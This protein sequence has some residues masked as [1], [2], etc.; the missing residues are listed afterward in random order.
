[1]L[2]TSNTRSFSEPFDAS[3]ADVILMCGP[4]KTW[5]SW[6]D[7][8]TAGNNV[9]ER[10]SGERTVWLKLTRVDDVVTG[11]VSSD[12]TDWTRVGSTTTGVS[13]DDE[14]AGVVVTSHVRGTLNTSTFDHVELRVR[15]KIMGP[16]FQTLPPHPAAA[17]YRF[18]RR[19]TSVVTRSVCAHY[20]VR[21]NLSV[22][23]RAMN[24]STRSP[25]RHRVPHGCGAFRSPGRMTS[26]LICALC[27]NGFVDVHDP[28]DLRQT[29]I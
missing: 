18:V 8:A 10:H 15:S 9:R 19:R 3:G 27:R 28:Y 7:Q 12:G 13:V 14:E 22:S 16:R 6:R 1:M 11:Y 26:A 23:M 2:R 17:I 21:L 24:A 29:G 20:P 25:R 5:S 4:P